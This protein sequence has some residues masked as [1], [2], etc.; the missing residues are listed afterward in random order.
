MPRLAPLTTARLTRDIQARDTEARDL[1]G[2]ILAV[3]TPFDAHGEVDV[4]ALKGNAC[5]PLDAGLTGLVGNGPRG[6]A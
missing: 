1:L 6:R 3:T 4:D 2:V 5:S